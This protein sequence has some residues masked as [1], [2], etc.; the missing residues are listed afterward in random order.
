MTKQSPVE[1]ETLLILHFDY[2]TEEHCPFVQR[3]VI[4]AARA[5][6]GGRGAGGGRLPF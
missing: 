5:W 4:V 3:E 2:G 6:H 1:L